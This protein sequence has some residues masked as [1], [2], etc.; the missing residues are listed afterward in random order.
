MYEKAQLFDFMI[1][2]VKEVARE[3]GFLEPQGFAAWFIDMYF[4]PKKELYVSDGTAD[5]KVDAFFGMVKDGT[6]QHYVLNTK[7]TRQ[8]DKQAPVTFYDEITRFWQAFANKP[9]RTRYL[10]TVRTELR[11][12]YKKLFDHYD[13]GRAQLMFITNHRRNEKQ[14]DSVRGSGVQIFHL[15]E[16]TQF[17]VDYIEDA[18]PRTPEMLLTGISAV[19]SPDKRDTEVSTSIVFARLVD[20]IKYMQDDDYGLL[21]ARNVRLWLGNTGVNKEIR[22]TFVSSPREFAFSNNGITLLCERHRHDPGSQEL[23]IENPRIVNGS[24]TLHSVRDIENPSPHARVMVRIIEIPPSAASD[25]ATQVQK[26][27]EVIQKISVRSNLQNTIKKWNLV[28]NDDF[29]H[30]LA[31]YFRKKKLFYERREKEWSYRRTE[32]KSVGINRGPEIRHLT[33]LMASYY[34]KSGVLGPATAKVAVSNLF[35]EKPYEKI[36]QTSH[37]LAYR[38]Y[39]LGKIVDGCFWKLAERKKYI[40]NFGGHINLTLFSVAVKALQSLGLDLEKSKCDSFLEDEVNVPRGHWVQLTKACV[41]HIRKFYNEEANAYRRSVGKGLTFNN[42]FKTQK[43][44][45]KILLAPV[46]RHIIKLARKSA[47]SLL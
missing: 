32:L 30:G 43:Y 46:P 34:W 14:F 45:I 1:Q 37:E 41:D 3:R 38:I 13:E 12:R 7:F 15:E 26:R 10:N 28:S 35:E 33:Q 42:Y 36:M 39:L 24:Q 25:V 6:I 21:F 27:K 22:K 18:M 17:L 44:V 9:A 4:G 2:R 47:K 20:F 29:Q 31:R 5:G 11:L 16:L 23:R 40:S 19:L 8:Y